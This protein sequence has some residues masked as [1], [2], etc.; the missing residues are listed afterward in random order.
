MNLSEAFDTLN[1]DFLIAKLHAYG[2]TAKSL[3]MVKSYLTNRWQ[4][5]K[6]NT[7]SSSWR[8]LPIGVPQG[9]VLGPLLFNIYINDL[10]Y[11]AEMTNVCNC[12]WYY[13][14]CLWLIRR[15]EY[16]SMLAVEWFESNYMK[17]NNDKCHL[18]LSGYKH[19]IMWANIGQSQIWESKGQ[20]VLGVII[21]SDMNFG[22]YIQLQCKKA[23]KK[24]CA[25]GRVCKFL[26]LERWRSLMKAFIES[27]FEYCPLVWMFCC[28]SSKNRINHLHKRALRIFYNDHSS[29]F[30]I[31]LWRITQFHFIT[32]TF[33]C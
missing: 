25:L 21:D 11:I 15:L 18:L 32:G 19:E 28:R 7:N 33:A 17:L 23:G 29:T 30:E 3:K 27:Q 5:T 24:L 22:E 10:F 6:A 16:G 4:R 8:E 2:F 14:S 1:H 12:W 9:S 26:S 13:I 20:K 31:F